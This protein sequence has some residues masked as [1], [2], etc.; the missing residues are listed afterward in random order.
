[1]LQLGDKEVISPP[2]F[3][4]DLMFFFLKKTH[5]EHEWVMIITIISSQ[6]AILFVTNH[7]TGC[8]GGRNVGGS[9]K[10]SPQL[11]LLGRR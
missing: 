5:H 9:I 8:S 11:Q 1:M 4:C 6:Y 10:N 2:C 7:L 3:K